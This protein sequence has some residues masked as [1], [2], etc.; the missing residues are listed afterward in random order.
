MLAK[1]QG[2]SFWGTEN[3]LKLMVMMVAKLYEYSKKSWNSIIS[4]GKLYDS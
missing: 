2:V 3:I 1:M 4:M